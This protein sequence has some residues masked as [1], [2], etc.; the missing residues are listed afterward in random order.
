MRIGL[1]GGTFNP[2]HYAHL[3]MASRALEVCHLD[4]VL[5]IPNFKA[6][7]KTSEEITSFHHR[8]QMVELA[9][10]SHP[11]FFSSAIES[12]L[13]DGPSYT[14]YTLQALKKTF[15]TD[16]FYFIVGSDSLLEM[17]RWY[18]FK[19]LFPL[20]TFVYFNRNDEDQAK[21]ADYTTHLVKKYNARILYAGKMILHLSS[22][23]LRN[24][25]DEKSSV[26]YL[27]PD[28]VWRYADKHQ[29]YP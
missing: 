19:E 20:C 18:H 21:Q 17:E 26:R 4:R 22:T 5:F 25:W 1:L 11:R 15:P 23:Y 8:L 12:E 29:L 3:Y 6:P 16:E 27:T 28:A 2:I 7:H 13:S 14:L 9:I 10:A 24:R